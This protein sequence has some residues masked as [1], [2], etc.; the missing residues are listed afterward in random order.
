M[1]TST[2]VALANTTLVSSATNISFTSIPSTYRDLV[3]VVDGTPSASGVSAGLIFNSD[4]GLNYSSVIISGSGSAAG[5][6][7]NTNTSF[8][9]CAFFNTTGKMN[10]IVQILDYSATDKHKSL[11]SRSND[12]GSFVIAYYARW[13][14]TAAINSVQVVSQFAAGTTLS[15]YGIAS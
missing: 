6:A 13:A 15:L 1:P 10:F 11:L 5:A 4:S 12:A 2:Y 9:D 14:N 8:G 7:G 3:L